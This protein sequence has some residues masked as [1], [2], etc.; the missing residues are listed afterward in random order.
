MI[1]VWTDSERFWGWG[2]QSKMGPRRPKLAPGWL[3]VFHSSPSRPQ[4]CPSWLEIGS[5]LTPSWRQL[6]SRWLQ[7]GPSLGRCCPKLAED[8][9][10]WPKLTSR[11]H[12]GSFS[13]PSGP[14]EI[15]VPHQKSKVFAKT[16]FRAQEHQIGP[17]LAQVELNLS[18]F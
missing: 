6:G 9:P 14:S 18:S 11:F 4:G 5:K 3:H 12:L 17:K 7:F 8:R 10:K 1:D 2:C 13:G 15:M 16:N